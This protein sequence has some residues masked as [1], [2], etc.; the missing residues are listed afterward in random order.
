M[1]EIE[2]VV[3]TSNRL[4]TATALFCAILFGASIVL[5]GWVVYD[6]Q[7]QQNKTN[8]TVCVAV[9]NLNA[10]ITLSLKRSLV[11]IPKLA[12]Y[13]EHP[14]ERDSQLAEVRRTLVT[15]RPRSCN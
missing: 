10:A 8:Q 12:Y 13:K 15:F 6:N 7:I 11:N 1:S 4:A 2:N 9:N 5:V 3:K 14:D